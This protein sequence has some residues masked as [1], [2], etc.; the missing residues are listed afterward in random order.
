MSDDFSRDSL[1]PTHQLN[2]RHHN[3]P[4]LPYQVYQAHYRPPYHQQ[5]HYWYPP[6]RYNYSTP[7]AGSVPMTRNHMNMSHVQQNSKPQ[8]SVEESPPKKADI[9]VPVPV[10]ATSVLQPNPKPA[11]LEPVLIPKLELFQ[12]SPAENLEAVVS[13]S[14]SIQ[15][16]EKEM[17]GMEKITEEIFA[18]DLN[19]KHVHLYKAL[20]QI[21]QMMSST[22][23]IKAE[24]E[25]SKT[26]ENELRAA[27]A[28]LKQK[29]KE[30][31]QEMA[32]LQ[33]INEDV[34][35][36]AEIDVKQAKSE[37]QI[38][39]GKFVEFSKQQTALK[40]K[41]EEKDKNIRKLTEKST[42][43]KAK[44][45]EQRVKVAN[46][47]AAEKL[48]A[49]FKLRCES[50]E[51]TISDKDKQISRISKELEEEKNKNASKVVELEEINKIINNLNDQV[52]VL[53]N[54]KI[55][56]KTERDSFK[57][58]VEK[59][60]A[61]NSEKCIEISKISQELEKER[62]YNKVKTLELQKKNKSI[63]DLKANVKDL[64][65]EID[66]FPNIIVSQLLKNYPQNKRKRTLSS[67]SSSSEKENS[68]ETSTLPMEAAGKNEIATSIASNEVE[69]GEIV[70]VSKANFYTAK[71]LKADVTTEDNGLQNNLVI[72][73]PH[74]F[75][76]HFNTVR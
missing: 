46:L 12:P 58:S 4:R 37:E 75:Q 63:K 8:V 16:E 66:D 48:Q 35:K 73:I 55:S 26:T 44:L 21:V 47:Q 57:L 62:N 34:K 6:Q 28:F 30:L 36:K 5:H 19:S 20:G 29:F 72:T 17:Q 3:V 76:A 69:E 10:Q 2:I 67:S 45:N 74:I 41:S 9:V 71:K 22:Y 14:P 39:R 68:S 65:K 61:N 38:W 43:Q 50:L 25:R 49:Y 18:E 60:Q 40:N 27:N 1:H 70:N 33:E 64:E 54:N 51:A 23:K 32:T 53:K 13:S 11:P 42:E 15:L 52:K 31:E 56:I 24:A 7:I 59:L